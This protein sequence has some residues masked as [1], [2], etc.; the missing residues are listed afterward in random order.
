MFCTYATIFMTD[1]ILEFVSD[2]S[3]ILNILTKSKDNGTVVGINAPCLGSGTFISVVDD[4]ILVDDII[5]VLKPFDASGHMLDTN[6]IRLSDVTSVLPF[7]SVFENP[8]H[9]TTQFIRPN[10]GHSS[11][12]A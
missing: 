12:S 9:K 11:P 3:F 5:I 2:R 7:N 4:I 10:A 1:T 8:F 6:K